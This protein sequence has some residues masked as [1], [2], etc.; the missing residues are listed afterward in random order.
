VAA[1]GPTICAP[2]YEVSA[3]LAQDFAQ[4]FAAIPTADLL[5]A[6]RH[7]NLRAVAEHQLREGGVTAI[8]HVGGCTCCARDTAGNPVLRSY[9]RG[10]RNSQ[11]HAGLYIVG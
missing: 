9:R 4:R 6:H 2:C 7:L 11:Q 10:D 1:I 8:D 3:A 5:P